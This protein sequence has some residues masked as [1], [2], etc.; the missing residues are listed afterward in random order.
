MIQTYAGAIV[1]DPVDDGPS[2]WDTSGHY[3]C[4]KIEVD[5]T[6]TRDQYG[7]NPFD[8]SSA[9]ALSALFELAVANE[10]CDLDDTLTFNTPTG[11]TFTDCTL[12]AERLREKSHGSE[13]NWFVDVYNACRVQ[14][15]EAQGYTG[16]TPTP[17]TIALRTTGALPA[18]AA[19]SDQVYYSAHRNQWAFKGAAVSNAKQMGLSYAND[20]SKFSKSQVSFTCQDLDTDASGDQ[21]NIITFIG[22]TEL[23]NAAIDNIC[24]DPSVVPLSLDDTHLDIDG[25]KEGGDDYGEKTCAPLTVNVRQTIIQSDKFAGTLSSGNT[26]TP[27]TIELTASHTKPAELTDYTLTMLFGDSETSSDATESA[28]VTFLTAG[29]IHVNTESNIPAQSVQL[30]YADTTGHPETMTNDVVGTKQSAMTC[31]TPETKTFTTGALDLPCSGTTHVARSYDIYSRYSDQH[32][33]EIDVTTSGMT[34]K[35]TT[36]YYNTVNSGQN[37]ILLSDALTFESTAISADKDPALLTVGITSLNSQSTY[38]A[39]DCSWVSG[40]GGIVCDLKVSGTRAD[41]QTG[42]VD[43]VENLDFDL[44]YNYANTDAQCEAGSSSRV[45][46]NAGAKSGKTMTFQ[47][48][49]NKL[50]GRIYIRD[51][52]NDKAEFFDETSAHV[53]DIVMSYAVPISDANAGVTTTPKISITLGAMSTA[54]A[55]AADAGKQTGLTIFYKETQLQLVNGGDSCN[56]G[57][58]SFVE[59]QTKASST[60]ILEVQQQYTASKSDGGGQYGVNQAFQTIDIAVQLGSDD[61]TRREI[62]LQVKVAPDDSVPFIKTP[63]DN[64]LEFVSQTA[65]SKE[66]IDGSVYWMY[67]GRYDSVHFDMRNK[68]SGTAQDLQLANET[69]IFE[70]ANDQS[71]RHEGVVSTPGRTTTLSE[72]ANEQTFTTTDQCIS[73]GK[74]AFAYQG[75]CH[76]VEFDCKRHAAVADVHL[77]VDLDY[78]TTFT[79]VNGFKVDS[80]ENGGVMT[81]G[82]TCSSDGNVD[83]IES[84]AL[85]TKDLSSTT[86]PVIFSGGLSGMLE[87]FQKC[88]DTFDDTTVDDTLV[89]E[90]SAVRQY[91]Q[92]SQVFCHKKTLELSVLTEGEATA[93]IAVQ[94]IGAINFVFW[95]DKFYFGD[96]GD[97]CSGTERKLHLVIKGTSKVGVNPTLKDFTTISRIVENSNIDDSVLG[98]LEFTV[99]DTA[100]GD[101]LSLE[102]Q[103][104][105]FCKDEDRAINFDFVAKTTHNTQEFFADVSG[106]VSIGGNPCDNDHI[107]DHNELSATL[108]VAKPDSKSDTCDV[109]Q[110]Y[111]DG[112]GISV[113]SDHALCYE[114]TP[115]ETTYNLT[116]LSSTVSKSSDGTSFDPPVPAAL[117]D[118]SGATLVANTAYEYFKLGD[119]Q[120]FADHTLKLTIHWKYDIGRSSRR[121]R[122]TYLLGSSDQESHAS[123][124]ILPAGVQIQEQIEAAP[125]HDVIYNGTVL[126]TTETSLPDHQHTNANW[127]LGLG[128]GGSV[129]GVGFI[130]V[131]IYTGWKRTENGRDFLGVGSGY[132]KVGRFETNMAF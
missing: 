69:I 108:K 107:V 86:D 35:E 12:I 2:G 131:W 11:A 21:F 74:V 102:T 93:T 81:L 3:T 42:V 95:T 31:G 34:V 36:E 48:Q 16:E 49:N 101:I 76:V 103:C 32:V 110:D 41:I 14:E 45:N 4:K 121:L 29:T 59:S 125:A 75:Q 90:M 40:S 24:R 84:D 26:V 51:I 27:A 123:I 25:S 8:T 132:R 15:P 79:I 94:S 77:N 80:I 99:D 112:T 88:H 37:T 50:G 28:T 89:W 67:N 7:S 22:G 60:L 62:T 30:S 129:V 1:A 65:Y 20:A 43:V 33:K 38:E 100:T 46:A 118:G 82:S 78:G 122:S 44:E 73:R 111:T 105:D 119:I 113:L 55:G 9:V 63:Q 116:Y 5:T 39:K 98:S 115:S 117:T 130:A 104:Q 87:S 56:G 120:P 19:S 52:D 72:F 97:G 10:E 66:D 96:A 64:D 54:N 92:G 124:Q 53:E 47:T 6:Q 68:L 70:P 58:C 71:C 106:L 126:N 114:L 61:T 23:G 18:T 91:T 13:L 85:C 128:I 109:S 127:G 17:T 57:E 83:E